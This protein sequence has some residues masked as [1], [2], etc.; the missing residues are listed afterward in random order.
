MVPILDDATANGK[1]VEFIKAPSGSMVMRFRTELSPGNFGGSGEPFLAWREDMLACCLEKATH[2]VLPIRGGPPTC[3]LPGNDMRPG[4]FVKNSQGRT[5]LAG[6]LDDPPRASPAPP[7]TPHPPPPPP[8]PSS[9]PSHRPRPRPDPSPGPAPQPAPTAPASNRAPPPLSNPP[10]PNPPRP[11]PNTRP[12]P[13]P[14]LPRPRSHPCTSPSTMLEP[15]PP[16]PC[17]APTP[18]FRPPAAQGG[19]LQAGL[20]A[21]LAGEDGSTLW[22]VRARPVP[23]RPAPPRPAPPARPSPLTESADR[24]RAGQSAGDGAD[25]PLGAPVAAADGHTQHLL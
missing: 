10:C 25:E 13:D 14:P 16:P 17:A 8:P 6:R 9:L 20:E 2:A 3:V 22:L 19:A 18:P 1:L 24:V 5:V 15:T 4:V 11:H 7:P 21:D 23:P 12:N